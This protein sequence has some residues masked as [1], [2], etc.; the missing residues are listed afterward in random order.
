MRAKRVKLVTMLAAGCAL[1]LVL[2]SCYIPDKFRAELQFSRYGDYR[3]TFDGEVMY[4]PMMHDYAEGKITP[5]DEP[6]RLEIVH[7]DLARDPA[8]KS[9]ESLGKGRFKVHYQREGTLGPNQLIALFRRDAAL[10]RMKSMPDGRIFIAANGIKPSDAEAMAKFGVGMQGEFR[11]TTD[12]NVVAHNAAEVRPFGA[13]QVYIW[14]IDNPLSPMPHMAI[15]RD[16]DPARI[17]Q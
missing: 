2:A 5:E 7:R 15:M 6:E 9:I 16:A 11:I 12:A 4:A 13:Y 3:M 1:M 14:H 8:V 17:P 10:I